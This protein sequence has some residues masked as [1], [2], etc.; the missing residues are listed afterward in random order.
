[1]YIT[2]VMFLNLPHSTFNTTYEIMPN[3][4]PLDIEYERGIM[5]MQMN[6]GIDSL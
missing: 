6:A 2:G 5:I 4:I 3:I 1:M